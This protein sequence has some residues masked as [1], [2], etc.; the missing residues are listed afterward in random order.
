MLRKKDRKDIKIFLKKKNKKDEKGLETDIKMFL[1]K[2]N[3]KN[4]SVSS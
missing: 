3:K 4:T 2:K 1:T